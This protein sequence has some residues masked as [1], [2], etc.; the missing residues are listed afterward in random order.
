MTTFFSNPDGFFSVIW[1]SL[2][3]W[4]SQQHE[5]RGDQP[6][7]YYFMTLPVYEFVPLALGTAGALY[8]VI[9]AKMA[10][11]LIVVGGAVFIAVLLQLPHAPAVMRCPGDECKVTA[12]AGVSLFHV[13]LPLVIVMIGVLA[14][15]GGESRSAAFSF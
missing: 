9:R 12:K 14:A 5:R 1:G 11:A 6:D 15:S 7:Y 13:L 10:N 3:Y 2:D 4:V 8:Y